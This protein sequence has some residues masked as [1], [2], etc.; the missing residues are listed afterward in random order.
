VDYYYYISHEETVHSCRFFLGRACAISMPG[1]REIGV[2]T[3][4]SH[5]RSGLRHFLES[6][7]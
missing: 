5:W 1:P 2:T 3:H 7:T 4:V 6:M